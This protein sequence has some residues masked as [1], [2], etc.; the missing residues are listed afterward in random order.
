MRWR[1]KKVYFSGY[2][3]TIAYSLVQFE[4]VPEIRTGC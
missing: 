4:V 1:L 3:L 2:D